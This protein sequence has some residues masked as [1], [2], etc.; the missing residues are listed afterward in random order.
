[1]WRP[2]QDQKSSL[3][4]FLASNLTHFLVWRLIRFT[5]LCI[6]SWD[7]RLRATPHSTSDRSSACCSSAKSSIVQPTRIRM[8][9][10][11]APQ[12]PCCLSLTT[13]VL[14]SSWFCRPQYFVLC[15]RRLGSYQSK[16]FHTSLSRGQRLNSM[17]RWLAM[18]S[19]QFSSFVGCQAEY[20]S[21]FYLVGMLWRWSGRFLHHK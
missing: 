21:S 12:S 6:L 16:V 4:H 19:H 10:R 11:E 15:S 8:E 2:Q 5:S 9:Y 13:Y 7:Y 14:S 17:H 18:Q 20:Q 1:M 3:V